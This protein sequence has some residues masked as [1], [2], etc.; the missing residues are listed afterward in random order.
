MLEELKALE[1][2]QTWDFVKLPE[3]KRAISCK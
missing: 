2:N 3:G 1:K